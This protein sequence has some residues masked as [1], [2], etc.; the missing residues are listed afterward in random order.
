MRNTMYSYLVVAVPVDANSLTAAQPLAKDRK[1]SLDKYTFPLLVVCDA[2]GKQLAVSEF[3][4]LSTEAKL[5]AFLEKHAPETLDARKILADALA[6][7]KKENK[8]VLVQETATWCGPCQRMSVFLDAQRAV[9]S[10]DYVWVKIDE[11]WTHSREVMKGIRKG[12]EG[13]IPWH[14]ILDADG[15]VL[16]TC[17]DKT[18]ANVGFPGEGP[19]I[20][21]FIGMFEATAIRLTA[22]EIAALRKALEKR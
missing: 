8:R 16:A 21:H 22:G 13:G 5:T 20:A 14:A 1:V 7:A 12:A 10:K 3:A 19:G 18:G 4:P 6:R 2:D 11:R 17:I 9:W 15:R